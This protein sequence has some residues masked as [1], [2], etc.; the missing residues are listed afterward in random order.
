MLDEALAYLARGW[1]VVPAH[2]LIGGECSCRNTKCRS[3]GKHPRIRWRAFQDRLPSETEVRKWWTRRG[4]QDSN[5]V[6]VTGAVSNLIVVDIDPRHGGDD[7][8]ADFTKRHP[9]RQWGMGLVAL[10]GGGGSHLYYIRPQSERPIENRANVLPGM[11]VRGDGGYVIGPPSTRT[12][13]DG[14]VVSQD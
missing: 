3:K 5:I 12:S 8:W 2:N 7:S 1:S 13:I 9:A 14:E 6:I 4:W 10:T 11:D